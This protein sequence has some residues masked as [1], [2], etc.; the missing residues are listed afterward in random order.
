MATGDVLVPGVGFAATTQ[1][2]GDVGSA[3]APGYGLSA[4]ARW[5]TVPYQLVDVP[6]GIG[7][8]ARHLNGIDR[9]E[10][11]AN[12]GPWQ[13]ASARTF[14]ASNDR[15]E[16][17][18][19][20]DPSLFA[21][22]GPVE[23]RAIVY[24]LGAGQPIVL[25]G[26]HIAQNGAGTSLNELAYQDYRSL[27]LHVDPSGTIRTT[28]VA[29]VSPI[30][31]NAND[32]A[33]WATAKRTLY[34]GLQSLQARFGTQDGGQVICAAGIHDWECSPGSRINAVHGMATF[35]ADPSAPPESVILENDPSITG[36]SV[37]SNRI[38]IHGFKINQRPIDTTSAS[39]PTLMWMHRCVAET[40]DTNVAPLWPAAAQHQHG[41]FLTE[42]TSRNSQHGFRD[43]Y[44][45]V[46][47]C[48]VVN[49]GEDAFYHVLA[50]FECSVEGVIRASELAHAD[51]FQWTGLFRNLMVE[52]VVAFNTSNVQTMFFSQSTGTDRFDNCYFGNI[53][54]GDTNT[55]VGGGQFIS[56]ANHV[57]FESITMDAS[58]LFR[59]TSGATPLTVT[60]VAVRDSVFRLLTWQTGSGYP[61]AT[62]AVTNCHNMAGVVGANGTGGGDASTLFV[63]AAANDYTP[64]GVLL[65]R[66][67]DPRIEVDVYGNPVPRD[68]TAAIGAV[69]NIA[70]SDT[71]P[72]TATVNLAFN[73]SPR[74]LVA[75][76]DAD[77]QLASLAGRFT[78]P[79]GA[80]TD[81]LINDF[82][83]NASDH[84]Y[85]V[86]IDDPA[87]GD[88]S[89]AVLSFEDTSGN[90]GNSTGLS[91][92]TTVTP[93]P[94]VTPPTITGFTASN[95]SARNISVT[96]LSNEP[97]A[98]ASV[99]IT[100]PSNATIT[101]FGSAT[102]GPLT[103]YTGSVSVP[104]DGQYTATLTQA[105]DSAGNNGSGG[106]PPSVV[107]IDRTA[108]TVSASVVW[109]NSSRN[110]TGTIASNEPLSVV[111]A[112]WV[113][114]NDE[115]SAATLLFSPSNS[116]YTTTL[117]SPTPA[118]T[119]RLQV[120]TATDA[121]G[122]GIVSPVSSNSVTVTPSDIDPPVVSVSASFVSNRITATVVANEALL[123]ISG[124][125]IPPSGPLQAAAFT[126]SGNTYTTFID[127]PA[128]GQWQ[129]ELLNAIDL[130]GN[131]A[132]VNGMAP[133]VVVPNASAGELN[134]SVR[135]TRSGQ[136]LVIVVSSDKRLT[137]IDLNI[138]G[139]ITKSITD[140]G[141]F[142]EEDL[143]SN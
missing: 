127:A 141:L 128:P 120:N 31:N 59:A 50:C 86:T 87:T 77:E 75:T 37:G 82:A 89:F 65:N 52:N 51:I 97:I 58:M 106:V 123:S 47:K 142:T 5:T 39:F 133:I 115:E 88:W 28:R 135:V 109:D 71:A 83:Y 49:V 114:P 54:I 126:Q 117:S 100:G 91:D 73:N 21:Q 56:N 90:S 18:V 29:Y 107:S 99:S 23:I 143:G 98:S 62:E 45:L 68:G 130:A 8:A 103:R 111:S 55:P 81:R 44:R 125:W 119:W 110:L 43:Q 16:Y 67:T 132:D 48:N 20:L 1:T 121:N 140:I 124:R 33:S 22:E 101:S 94:D 63:D 6:L 36:G 76:V 80:T 2:P 61:P 13:V 139:P 11:S 134:L 112:V 24:P 30:G 118:G 69:Q 7:L 108:P 14:N 104:S 15:T 25:Q 74:S 40:G 12:G 3:G 9:V 129:F 38:A 66:I 95:P 46:R 41:I 78:A 35:V 84:T 116:T 137:G 92:S 53:L 72:P 17:W 42:C 79:G 57:I 64:L 102:E 105:T 34:G 136:N 96:F 93:P 27:F 4:I 26:P 85:T 10:F 122:N 60:N 131:A 138:D 32:G 113:D 19:T 70:I